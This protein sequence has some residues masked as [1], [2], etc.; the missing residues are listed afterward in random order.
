V[1]V[2]TY[3][4]SSGYTDKLLKDLSMA[5]GYNIV[6]SIGAKLLNFDNEIEKDANTMLLF[7]NGFNISE[8][9]LKELDLE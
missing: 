7:I 4:I 1:Y 3:A 9:F 2:Y 5:L 8:T 6:G